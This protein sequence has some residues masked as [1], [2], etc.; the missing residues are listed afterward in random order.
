MVGLAAEMA[1][2]WAEVE[3]V[4]RAVE[5]KVPGVWVVVITAAVS[6]AVQS[7]GLDSTM[8]PSERSKL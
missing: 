3:V 2:V 7:M 1:E 5:V 6:T 4:E 8:A